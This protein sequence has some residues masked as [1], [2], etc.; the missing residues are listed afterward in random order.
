MI[1]LHLSTEDLSRIRFSYSPLWELVTSVRALRDAGR[2]ALHLP[3]RDEARRA[4]EEVD[5]GPLSVLVP[6]ERHTYIPDFVA[7]PPEDGLPDF[8]EELAR[9]GAVEP[10]V[11]RREARRILPRHDGV[12]PALRSYLE[13]PAAARARLVETLEAYWEATLAPRWNRIR[14]VLEGEVLYRAR[15]LAVEGVAGLFEGLHREVEVSGRTVE[16]ERSFELEVRPD[17][18]GLLMAPS[19]FVWP[20]LYVVADRAWQPAIRYPARGVAALW[21]DR[22]ADPPRAAERLLGGS[23][24]RVLRNLEAPV[25]T[26]EL[27]ERLGVT[28]AAV[29]QHLGRL[30]EA[31]VVASERVGRRV[32]HRL[33]RR[34]R[35]VLVALR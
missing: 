5:I 33:N 13:R 6:A 21:T 35:A 9:V 10:K 7:P 30:K 26:G 11:L 17:G 14:S 12:P 27:A 24:A 8:E 22:S 32:F 25:S 4:L 34:G 29:S 16:V 2:H 15:R 19:V 18:E 1:R 3:W 28:S 31:G 20:D 23:R